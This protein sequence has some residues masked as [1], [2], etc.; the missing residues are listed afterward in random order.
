[1]SPCKILCLFVLLALFPKGVIFVVV[2]LTACPLACSVNVP[3]LSKNL[4]TYLLFFIKFEERSEI[5]QHSV[6]LCT[7]QKKPTL[8]QDGRQAE[9]TGYADA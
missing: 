4:G 6:N 8:P 3:S 9:L 7:K 2:V 1:M 5:L